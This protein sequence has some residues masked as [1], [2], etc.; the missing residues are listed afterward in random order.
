MVSDVQGEMESPEF[1]LVDVSNSRTKIAG[2]LR[3]R[4]TGHREIVPTADL[5]AMSLGQLEWAKGVER[6]VL[7]SVVPEKN[8]EFAEVFGGRLLKVGHRI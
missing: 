7:S 6:I 5:E 4:L 3:D 8:E 2:A 1:L